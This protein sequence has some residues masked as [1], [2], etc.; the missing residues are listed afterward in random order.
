MSKVV[1]KCARVVCP[2]YTLEWMYAKEAQKWNWQSFRQ[3]S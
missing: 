3:R 2:K 1:K